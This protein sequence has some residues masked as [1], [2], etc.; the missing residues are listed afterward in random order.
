MSGAGNDP[1]SGSSIQNVLQHTISP[2]IVT[3]GSGGYTV[4]ADLI[5]VDNVYVTGDLYRNGTS[6]NRYISILPTTTTT[7]S[8]ASI[9][10]GSV[11]IGESSGDTAHGAFT[12]SIGSG[13]GQDFQ[14]NGAVAIGASAGRL[15]QSS[16]GVAIGNGAGSTGQKSGAVAVGR[17][18]GSVNQGNSSIAIG[19]QSGYTSQ[20][21]NSIVVNATGS[22]LNNTVTNSFVV[23][24]I[25]QVSLSDVPAGS[26]QV[27]WNP[28]TGELMAVDS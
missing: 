4:K 26:V 22:I 2:K 24:P 21:A 15:E 7:N 23:K 6:I 14:E 19:C 9:V 1:F 8:P 25:R 28:A 10:G 20:A 17:S 13:A 12:T 27:Y 11:A 16:Y 3:D 18:A 5:N